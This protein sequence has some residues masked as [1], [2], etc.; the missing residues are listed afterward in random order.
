MACRCKD[1]VCSSP[2]PHLNLIVSLRWE[3]TFER[4]NCSYTFRGKL[5][6]F[7]PKFKVFG[8]FLFFS[9]R[10]LRRRKNYVAKVSQKEELF[11]LRWKGEDRL[12]DVQYL[13]YLHAKKFASLY[14]LFCQSKQ[15]NHDT[16]KN[17]V[18]LFNHCAS[19]RDPFWRSSLLFSFSSPLSPPV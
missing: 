7:F 5:F 8:V 19:V 17:L 14:K 15:R 4:S 10:N 12:R 18:S 9:A 13:F 6:S 11:F 1:L 3:K 2:F 16:S